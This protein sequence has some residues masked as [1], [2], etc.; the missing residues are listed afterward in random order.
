MYFPHLEVV[1]DIGTQCMLTIGRIGQDLHGCESCVF[2]VAEGSKT[3]DWS[4]GIAKQFVDRS[5]L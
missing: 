5:M 1:G 2:R 4:Q 3:R